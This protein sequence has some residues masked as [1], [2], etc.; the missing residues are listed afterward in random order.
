MPIK[1]DNAPVGDAAVLLDTH[2][3][4]W[5]AEG[6]A[7]LKPAKL[8]RI[9]SAFHSGNLCMSPI[10]A[11]EI[12]MLV[13]KKRLDLGQHPLGWFAAFV[14][15]FSINV[16]EITA[17]I[18]INSSYLPGKFQGDPAD[19]ILVATALAHA[20]ELVSADKEIISYGKRGLVQIFEI[21]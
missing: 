20:A 2:V 7:R 16:L 19:R 8:S 10:S 3:A 18:A 14:Q 17:E 6:S 15:Q 21:S 1:T 12:G 11:W 13:R 9:E 5:L 4:I